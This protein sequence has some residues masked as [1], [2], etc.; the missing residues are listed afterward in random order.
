MLPAPALAST[1]A[2]ARPISAMAAHA[3]HSAHVA[4][5]AHVAHA[6]DH[7]AAGHAAGHSTAGNHGTTVNKAAGNRA[8]GNRAAANKAQTVDRQVARAEPAT[9]P[10]SIP[11]QYG[12]GQYVSV[13]NCQGGQVPPPVRLQ[14][15][16]TP[17]HLTGTAPTPAVAK[18]MA[19]RGRYKTVYT[20]NLVVQKQVPVP[21][22]KGGGLKPCELG[23]GGA[24][25]GKNGAACHKPVTLNTGFGG[26]AGSV[27]AHHPR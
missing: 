21:A 23:Q 26:A 7:R 10:V 18:A 15:P 1:Q 9:A 4:H 14:Q 11:S 17:L 8:A 19:T 5:V 24:G 27:S 13:V 20:C 2:A 6:A 3:A 25:G 16:N 12:S 22:G